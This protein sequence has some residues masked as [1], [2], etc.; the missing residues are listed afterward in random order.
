VK[1]K[2][3]QRV[4]NIN[5]ANIVAGYQM[6]SNLIEMLKIKDQT[7]AS[8][9]AR[10]FVPD[11]NSPKGFLLVEVVLYIA[12]FS[13]IVVGATVGLYNLSSANRGLE[14]QTALI[15]ETEFIL[16]KIDLVLS[17]VSQ[18]FEVGETLVVSNS[19]GETLRIGLED[20]TVFLQSF[21]E[22]HF[23]NGD[24]IWVEE[25]EFEKADIGLSDRFFV[26]ISLEAGGEKFSTS[27][28]GYF[29]EK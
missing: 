5:L 21:S 8:R 17:D 13:I 3:R 1:L 16:K 4:F 18:I 23:L 9:R 11:L 29:N 22:K 7:L 2:A 15:N 20:G 6:S 27:R 14:Y 12:L 24:V 26:K 25:L 28:L 19:A 10:D